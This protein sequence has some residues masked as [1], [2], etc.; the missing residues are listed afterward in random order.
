MAL[1]KNSFTLSNGNTIPAIA[2]GTGTRW[3]KLGVAEIDENLVTAVSNALKVGFRH[4]DGAE[5]YNVDVEVGRAIKSSGLDRSEIFVTDKYFA[6]QSSFEPPRSVE[7][8]PRAA[9]LASLKRL[10]L[11]YVD[12]YLL[13]FPYI[14]KESH[15]FTL[16]EAWQYLELLV[17]D[18]YAKNIGVSNFTV[19]NLKE[20]LDSNPKYPPVVHQIEYL[21]YLQNQTPGIVDFSKKN[22]MQVMAYSPLGPITKGSPGP[23]DPL[24]EKLSKKYSRNPSQILLRW[25]LD[26]GV[27]AVTTSSKELRLKEYLDVLNFSLDPEDVEEIS[28]IGKQKILRQYSTE[29]SRYD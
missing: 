24:L 2:Y 25:V 17:D 10:Q 29:Y 8:N 6:G 14:S 26:T 7:P 1:N 15:G 9:A 21:A 27:L 3:F 19:E 20:I 22:G 4:I 16:V 23:L 12:L 5:A 18:G 28:I 11:D 13:H